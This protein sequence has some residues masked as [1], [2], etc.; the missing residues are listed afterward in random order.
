MG[1]EIT[2]RAHIR[3]SLSILYA[4]P[5]LLPDA[6]FSMIN[7]SQPRLEVVKLR[8][9]T[10]ASGQTKFIFVYRKEA[11]KKKDSNYSSIFIK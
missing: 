1:I 7:S 5:W 8:E 6:P 4:S 9:K 3:A 2:D 11:E 10:R